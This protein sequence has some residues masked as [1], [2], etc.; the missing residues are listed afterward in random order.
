MDKWMSLNVQG[1]GGS[2]YNRGDP[3]FRGEKLSE[4]RVGSTHRAVRGTAAV[5]ALEG[6]H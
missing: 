5:G 4:R 1:D 2:R 3:H 6:D